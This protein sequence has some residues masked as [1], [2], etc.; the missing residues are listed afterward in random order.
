MRRHFFP[1][2][3]P[4]PTGPLPFLSRPPG[5]P[6]AQRQAADLPGHAAAGPGP[7][8]ATDG[9]GAGSLVCPEFVPHRS[10]GRVRV[11]VRVVVVVVEPPSRGGALKKS[12]E[13]SGVEGGYRAPTGS[14]PTGLQTW[15][16]GGGGCTA[17]G[18]DGESLDPE[19][20]SVCIE[21]M[22]LCLCWEC[23]YNSLIRDFTKTIRVLADH[24]AFFDTV[25]FSLSHA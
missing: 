5:D 10:R 1:T 7:L 24:S 19:L 17:R 12:R 6:P 23:L 4:T 22:C 3:N 18:P 11:R 9:I 20:G 13:E 2:N 14:L 8:S 25:S 15:E 16:G 21:H